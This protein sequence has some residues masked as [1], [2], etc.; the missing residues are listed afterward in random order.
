VSAAPVARAVAGGLA[1]RRVQTAVIGLVVLIST[2]AAV[3][4]A[5]LLAESSAPFDHAFAA[6]HGAHVTA[7]VDPARASP[8][9]LAAA[10]RLPQVAAAAGPFAETTIG[11]PCTPVTVRL[12]GPAGIGL[13]QLTLAGRTSPG[14]AIDDVALVSGHWVRRPGQV[15]LQYDYMGGGVP[16]GSTLTMT[17]LPGTPRLTV[18]GIAA[19]VTGSADGWVLPAEIAKLRPPGAPASEQVLYRFR[20]AGTAAAVR[21]DSAALTAALPAGSVTGIQSYL[22]VRAKDVSRVAV[23][24]PFVIAFG[25]IGLVLSVLIVANVVSGAVA[26]GYSRIGILKSIGFTPGQIVAAYTGQGLVPAVAG[27]LAGVLAGSWL[28]RPLL[29]K[30]AVSYG[31]GVLGVPAWVDA[32]VPAAMCC[33]T[34]LAATVPALR[35]GRLSAVAAIAAGR[36]PRAGRG[37]AAHRMLSRLPLPRPVTVGLAGPFVRPARTAVTLAAVGLGAA[38]V[39]FAVGLYS[40]LTLVQEGQHLTNTVQV[41]IF[42]TA[43]CGA[44]YGQAAL[45]PPGTPG[46]PGQGLTGR[47]QNTILAAIH[48]L[49][50]T[51]HSAAE[52]DVQASVAGVAKPAQVIAFRGAAAWTG[53]PMVS[54]HWYS[55]PGQVVVPRHLLTVTGTAVGDTITISFAGRQIPVRIVG[56]VFSTDL[57]L[58]TDW[59]TLASAD[60]GLAPDQ[61]AVGLRPGT[62]LLAYRAALRPRL[63]P[64]FVPLLSGLGVSSEILSMLALIGALTLL[65]AITA[66]LGVLCTVVMQTR[67]R[68]HD[69]GVFKAL[70]MTPRQAITMMVCWVAGT[71]LAAGVLAVP[72]GVALHRY[73]LPVMFAAKDTGLPGRYLN[74]Y[75]T[76]EITGL[77]LAGLVIAV[78]GALLPAG[79][80]ARTPAASALRTE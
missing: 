76:W 16:V 54:G 77:A 64:G 46:T 75:G 48:A 31:V 32:A 13:Q 50:Q 29:A 2:A 56:V 60:P 58:I 53:Y 26:A 45:G 19:S 39:T 23:Y 49:P 44:A 17:G 4:A 10:A 66:A 62:P 18:V 3:L 51:L 67:E 33:L 9:Q 73:V 38:T 21:S 5:A 7:A 74:V 30:A 70:G 24:V 69:L 36:A 8:A 55:G 61:F 72:A 20:D 34:G 12:G 14:G 28:A 47:Q 41:K 6:R 42:S 59:Q 71:G 35:A 15:V 79:W 27:C 1:R 68:V 63:G 80:A 78:A 25:V 57:V 40:S 43:A 65:L 11:V 22:A 37:Y 52:A